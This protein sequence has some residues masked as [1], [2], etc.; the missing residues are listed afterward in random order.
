M[1]SALLRL[2]RPGDWVKNVFVLMPMVFWL[3]GQGREA[4]A[5]EVQAKAM[6]LAVAFAS[7]C[8]IASG[9]YCINDS[10]DAAEDRQHPV[11]RRRPVAAGQVSPQVAALL[12]LGLVGASVFL[13]ALA[14]QLL[15]AVLVAYLLLQVAYNLR[16]KRVPF[17]DV[18]ALA[19]GF[20]L[21][22]IG[23]A[24]AIGV[25]ISVWLILCVFFLTL[26]LGFIK[27]LCDMASAENARRAGSVVE[28]RPR[29]GYENRDELNWLLAVSGVLTVIMYLMYA[30]SDHA[31]RLFGERALAF[32]LLSPLVVIVIHRFYRRANHGLSDSPL[33]VLLQDRTVLVAILLFVSGTLAAL[34][35]PG[36]DK[37]LARMLLA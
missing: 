17:V 25:Q 9:F 7:F 11:K 3:P 28:W 29:A 19:T 6:A 27:R 32:A 34:Y 12:G 20:C 14:S 10:L 4:P 22:A 37:L 30:L 26:Y 2:L 23:G 15:V 13:G 35:A 5:G 24:A 16:L 18:A 1:P 36:V 31:R 8:L 33:D 21:R